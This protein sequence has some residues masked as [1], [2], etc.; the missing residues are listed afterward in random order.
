MTERKRSISN[1]PKGNENKKQ[2]PDSDHE[3]VKIVMP[4]NATQTIRNKK[5][6]RSGDA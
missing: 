6:I 4:K 1:Q 3:T 2:K 5:L